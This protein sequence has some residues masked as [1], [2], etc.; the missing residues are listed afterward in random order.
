MERLIQNIN[1]FKTSGAE[2]AGAAI[3]ATNIRG[4]ML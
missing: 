1:Y 3:P 4:T 2:V